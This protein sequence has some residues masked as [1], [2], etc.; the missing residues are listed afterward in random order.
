MTK[1]Y[2]VENICVLQ[3]N[4]C[5]GFIRIFKIEMLSFLDKEQPFALLLPL[6]LIGM[7]WPLSTLTNVI[8][9]EER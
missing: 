5:V 8:R 2:S 3:N 9:K 6:H 4:Y 1:K 7:E